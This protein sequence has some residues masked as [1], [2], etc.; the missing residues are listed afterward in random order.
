MDEK[1]LDETLSFF[2]ISIQRELSSKSIYLEM[3]NYNDYSVFKP[4]FSASGFEYS[5]HLN[6]QVMTTLGAEKAFGRVND[7]K[8]RQIKQ[9]IRSGVSCEISHNKDDLKAFYQIL[10]RLYRKKVK[11]PLFPFDFFDIMHNQSFTR[12]FVVKK[13]EQVLGGIFCVISDKVVYEWFICG[14]DIRTE[15]TYASALATWTAIEYAANNGFVYF[16]FM[17][18]GKQDERYGVREFKSKFG[19]I[20]MDHGRFLY[21]CKPKLYNFSKSILNLTKKILSK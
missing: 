10:D 18:A 13:G 21:I 8:R 20:L 17:G 7:S 12:F 15:K 16:D 5:S 9:S 2:L 6:I 19:G 11:K 1:I 14:E 4:V 3:R